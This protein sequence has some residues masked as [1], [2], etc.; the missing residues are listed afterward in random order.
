PISLG[1]F[2]LLRYLQT[3]EYADCAR[4]Q[5]S[6]ATLAEVEGLLGDYLVYILERGLKSV[7]FL[8]LLRHNARLAGAS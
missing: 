4:L 5:L 6:P 2:K 1:A 3:H 7:E 8:Q